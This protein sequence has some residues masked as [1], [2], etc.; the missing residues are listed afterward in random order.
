MKRFI[1]V[2]G[3]I[4]LEYDTSNSLDID[5]KIISGDLI[6]LTMELQL[7]AYNHI[8]TLVIR[9]K[10]TLKQLSINLTREGNNSRLHL[11]NGKYIIELSQNE[12][13]YILA[14]VLRY[15]RDG[16]AKTGHIHV[17]LYNDSGVNSNGTLTVIA[18]RAKEPMTEEEAK[19]ILGID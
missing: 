2:D 13:G 11:V 17:D 9:S 18:E 19:K 15:Y 1:E 12:L 6:L 16:Y 7:L 5:I 14:Y 10:S 4:C 3:E 8:S